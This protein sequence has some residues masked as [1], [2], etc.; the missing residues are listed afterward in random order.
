[1]KDICCEACRYANY[2]ETQG[3]VRW[4]DESVYVADFVEADHCCDEYEPKEDD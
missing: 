4:N 2:D 3:Y 1:M